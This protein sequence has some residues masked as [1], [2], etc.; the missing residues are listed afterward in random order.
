[1]KCWAGRRYEDYDSVTGPI[2]EGAININQRLDQ[3]P[4]SQSGRPLRQ[5]PNRRR[6]LIRVLSVV[7]LVLVVAA[8]GLMAVIVSGPTE[9]GI[10]RERVA[11][12]LQSD[13]GDAYHVDVSKAV[14]EYDPVLGLTVRVDDIDVHDGSGQVVAHIPS[15]RF[16][17][18]ALALLSFRVEIKQIELSSPEIALA[19]GAAGSIYLGNAN[20]PPPP[21]AANQP[22]QVSPAEI[23]AADGGFPDI[24]AAL[25]LMDRGIEPQLEHAI[26]A[27]FQRFA[28]VN[29]AFTITANGQSRRFPGTD[30]NVDLDRATSALQVTLATSGYG[31][32]W[33]ANIERDLDARSGSH[34]MTAVFSQLTIADLFPSLGDE[35]GLLSADIPLY[36][37]ASISFDKSGD[38][39]DASARLDFGAGMIRFGD[40]RDDNVLLDEA[41]VKVHWDIANRQ[42]VLDPSTFYFGQTR[43][44]VT[45]RVYPE[46]DPSDRR[47]GFEL[48]SPGAVLAPSDSG[49]PP[50]IAQ[51]IAISGVADLKAK[52]LNVE[53][54]IIQAQDAAIAA[55]GS[56]AF[57]GATPSLTMAATFSPMTVAQLKQMWVPLIASGARRWVMQHVGDGQLTSGRF[58]AAIPAGV[59]W[60]GKRPTLPDDA[61]HLNMA[62]DDVTFT[63]FGDLPPITNASGNVTVSG[64]TVGID[65][66]KGEVRTPS[67]TVSVDNGAFA[68]PNTAKRPADGIVEVQLSGNAAALGEI[69]DSDP[70]KA[71]QR[72][73]LVPSDLSGSGN[74]NVSL[75]F[76]MRDGL[77]DADVD[78]KVVVQTD[79]VASKKPVEGRKVSAANVT[80]TV[81]PDDLAVYGKA[82]IDGVG[83]DV[84]MSMPIGSAAGQGQPGDRRVR[85][86]LDDEARK[87]FGVG[88]DQ[89]L[90][91]TMSA[92]VSDIV[93]GQHYDIDLQKARVI[94]PGIGWTKGV[95]VPATLTFD[96]KPASGG[97]A[98][99]NLVLTGDGFGFSGS[100]ELDETY[101][102]V[103]A[104]IA[105]L[106]LHPGD[107]ISL[108]LTR[109]KSGYA[110]T[111]RGDSF[112]L[113][114][115]I[116][117][118]RDEND[119]TG[120]FPDL[121][122][123]A[124][125]D[126]LI[127][128][129]QEEV[130]GAALTLVSVG[131]ETQKVSFSGK[132][133]GQPI[134]LNFSVGPDGTTL[135]GNAADAGSLLRF[136]DLYTRVN[137]GQVSLTGGAD[138]NAPLLG[139]LAVSDFDITNEPAME[140]MLQVDPS[141]A[142]AANPQRVHFDRME[143]HFS[144]SEHVIAVE[145]A[146]LAGDTVGATFSGRYDLSAAQIDITGT[147]LPAYALNNMFGRIPLLGLALGGGSQEGLFGVTFKIS[148]PIDQPEVYF[149]PLS[150]V[151]PGIFRKIFE[152]TNPTQ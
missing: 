126:H 28:V 97:Y 114:G 18:D 3:Y 9:F 16:A 149:N 148:G 66:D 86:L 75:R 17:I 85:L 104:D 82:K 93:G 41:T 14:I 89:V 12:I 51:R 152:F 76:P 24:I 111:A 38:V 62:L 118:V 112:D 5:R 100:A 122:L 138:R 147:Y 56:M 8:V 131:G 121:A 31:G 92:V 145:D 72:R 120:G 84:S 36:G 130:D 59:L 39:Q 91:G 70:L 43:G 27:G 90:S 47:Y 139:T 109:S 133:G 33:T 105:K 11:A 116:S 64:S 99:N 7:L 34:I 49:L 15:T 125:I 151:A 129:N 63:T 57:N 144:R 21:S 19:R 142:S 44:V 29:G 95:G 26:D 53:N 45:G 40:N 65:V 2:R 71:L 96:V 143:A 35:Q 106:S 25:Y 141:Q 42:L 78:W 37:R 135:N 6:L 101:N 60:T 108:K 136:T 55:A 50:I 107:N 73:D 150:A 94:L 23:D 132:I 113:R 69:A 32:R 98:V 137:G 134:G 127:G 52:V 13:L 61:L 110:L 10:V 124:R 79:D 140:R 58:E 102:L 48:E 54:A 123:D 1:M 30:F 77:T 128:Y 115:M 4:S 74:A 68:V 87:R 103:S 117:H 20:S 88:L 81:T 67:G 46:G 146:L 119:Q 22:S 80:L 83:A